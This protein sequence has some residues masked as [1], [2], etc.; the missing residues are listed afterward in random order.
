MFKAQ[1]SL[2]DPVGPDGWDRSGRVNLFQ[3]CLLVVLVFGEQQGQ[4]V[5]QDALSGRMADV[6]V[7]IVEFRL[8]RAAL[9]DHRTR[10]VRGAFAAAPGHTPHE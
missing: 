8:G 6:V 7:G 2:V 9:R 1:M 4:R 3:C 10:V 5:A